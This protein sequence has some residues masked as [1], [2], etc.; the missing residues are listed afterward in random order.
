LSAWVNGVRVDDENLFLAIRRSFDH[1]YFG[2]GACGWVGDGVEDFDNNW[3][4]G[5]SGAVR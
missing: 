1:D 2:I 3:F 5:R 4:V